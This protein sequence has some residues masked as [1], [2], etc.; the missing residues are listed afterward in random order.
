M[1]PSQRFKT[2]TDACPV[3]GGHKD[4]PQGEGLRCFGFISGDWTPCP[5]HAG[6]STPAVLIGTGTPTPTL[7]TWGEPV[8]AGRVHGAGPARARRFPGKRSGRSQAWT[9]IDTS[10]W[11]SRLRLWPYR[12]ATTGS[13]RFTWRGGTGRAAARKSAPWFMRMGSGVR[14]AYPSLD[15]STTGGSYMERPDAPV[16]VVEGEKTNDAASQVVP[17]P[18]F[19]PHR[20]AGQ[21]QPV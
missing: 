18:T 15:L 2:W 5:L 1:D 6:R 9:P 10:S 17:V 4:L 14:G 13:W 16:L 3:C 8:S 7:T 19:P 21:T 20:W 12:Y 11:E